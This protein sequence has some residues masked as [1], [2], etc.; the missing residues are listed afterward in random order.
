MKCECGCGQ[1]TPLATK[2]RGTLGHVKGQPVRFVHGHNRRGATNSEFQRI[3]L[4]EAIAGERHHFWKGDEVGYQSLHVWVRRYKERTGICEEC[5]K[6]RKTEFANISG[7]YQ[8]DVD[9]YAELCKPCHR[10]FDGR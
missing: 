5:G 10:E 9:D 6:E 2:T 3:R 8:R 4:R 7:E 1:D